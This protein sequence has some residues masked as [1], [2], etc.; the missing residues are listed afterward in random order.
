MAS[1]AKLFEVENAFNDCISRYLSRQASSG[2]DSW[3]TLQRMMRMWVS[4]A[5]AKVQRGDEQK[6]YD[7]YKSKFRHSKKIRRKK[8][9]ALFMEWRE[10]EALIRV[11]RWGGHKKGSLTGDQLYVEARK[12]AIKRRYATGVHRGG[13][14]PAFKVLGAP[15]K[16][17]RLGRVPKYDKFTTGNI[18]FTP[19]MQPPTADEM[20]ITV[21]NYAK[22]IEEIA[23]K[24]F[25]YSMVE[26]TTLFNRYMME[27]MVKA[28]LAAGLDSTK[29]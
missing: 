7:F 13:F 14:K 22:V 1:D 17:T 21:T 25:E 19:A 15:V 6:I 10:T 26:I 2:K 24:A 8:R 29:S 5:A 20:A 27:D 18:V 16:N 12:Y 11:V 9:S 4:F 3:R 28:Q 23:P